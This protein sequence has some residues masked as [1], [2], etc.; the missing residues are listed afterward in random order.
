VEINTCIN[1][2]DQMKILVK[3]KTQKIIYLDV[4]PSLK[5]K[6]VKHIIHDKEGIPPEE[7]MLIFAGRQLDDNKTLEDY[8]IVKQST[9]HLALK[10][11][12]NIP[13]NNI[14][15]EKS[16]FF[17]ENKD[18]KIDDSE[19]AKRNKN[20]EYFSN[21]SNKIEKKED[22]NEINEIIIN[23][24]NDNNHFDKITNLN[25]KDNNTNQNTISNI[26]NGNTIK[27]SDTIN[28]INL[29][30]ITTEEKNKINIEPEMNKKSEENM[31]EFNKKYLKRKE[32][33]VN[34]IHFD[35][36]MTILFLIIL[37]SML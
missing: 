20:E 32:L 3:T 12:F 7:Q 13:I 25:K 33:N 1:R 16:T 5:I 15:N 31:E 24:E 22:K 8:Y 14:Q 23:K 27:F 18:K 30:N 19:K 9:L 26:K 37:K 17:E 21:A 35:L 29:S 10:T 2:N 4:K 28:E 6:E 36:N 34:L 11:D